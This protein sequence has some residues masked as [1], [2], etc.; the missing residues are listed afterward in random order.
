MARRKFFLN[1]ALAIV[2]IALVGS[3]GLYIHA[4][5]QAKQVAESQLEEPEKEP[6]IADGS[7]PVRLSL[8]ALKNLGIFSKPLEPV[9]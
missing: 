9:K 2:V 8:E 7:T 5:W 1:I 4:Q 3:M 6:A